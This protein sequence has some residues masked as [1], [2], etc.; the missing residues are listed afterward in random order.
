MTSAHI[1][2]HLSSSSVYPEN[3]A[4]AFDL[5]QRLGYD[6]VEI[7]VWTDP[8]TQE[9]GALRAL[10]D[11][12]EITI[13]AIHAPTLLLA[14]R[15]WGWEPWG[16][17]ERALDLAGEVGAQCVVVHPPFRWQRGYAEGF[18]EGVADRQARW[19][20]DIAVENMFPWRSGVN[21]MQAY[22]PG[23]DPRDF[24]YGAVTLDISHAATAGMDPVQMAQDLG[25]RVRHLHLGD[26]FGSFKDEHLVPG[27]GSQRCDEVLRHF[28]DHAFSGIVSVEVGTRRMRTPARELALA[29]SLAYARTHLGQ[30]D[31]PG[32]TLEPTR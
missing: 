14:Q 7:M 31:L 29:E 23:P 22:L 11:L 9:A 32:A 24:P 5:A 21:A 13:G 15:L 12:H 25:E 27:R 10:A 18:V 1:P 2:V 3:A 19:G 26:S 8:V 20:I 4:Y 6:G 30:H 28:A 16:K 17:I